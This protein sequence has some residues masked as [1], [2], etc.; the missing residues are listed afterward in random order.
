MRQRCRLRK[1]RSNY[2][3]DEKPLEDVPG[4][5]TFSSDVEAVALAPRV[6]G[7]LSEESIGGDESAG[8]P[9]AATDGRGY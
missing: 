1:L 8:A 6:K 9:A 4:Y 7:Q 3:L 5:E 2:R